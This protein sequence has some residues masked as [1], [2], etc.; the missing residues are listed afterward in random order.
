MPAGRERVQE[1]VTYALAHGDEEAC[2]VYGINMASLDRYR[3]VFRANFGEYSELL[4]QI[5]QRYKPEELKILAAGQ[6]QHKYIGVPYDFEGDIVRFGYLTDTHIGSKYTDETAISAALE[7][8]KKRECQFLV[9]SGDVFEGMSGR[10]GHVYELSSIGYSA[11]KKAGVELMKQWDRPAYYIA[12]NHDA[13]YMKKGD[14]GANIV[15]EFCSEVPQAHFLGMNEGD[16]PVNGAVI[17]LWHGEDGSSYAISYRMQKIVE[18]FTGGEKPNVLLLGHAHK[19]GNF[20]ERNIHVLGGGTLQ[21]Q[22]PFMRYKRLA[23]V[24]GFYVVTMC[25][26]NSSIVWFEPRWY[27]LYV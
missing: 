25:I 16:F 1:V 14:M 21:H 27:P 11:Q 8:F 13:W 7:E 9:H 20:F 5:S 3:R 4:L 18:A 24:M 12:G 10:D 22:T 17:K 19:Q 23:A 26:K 6:A 2:E 15:E